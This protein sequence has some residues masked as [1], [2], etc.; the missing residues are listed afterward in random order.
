MTT[1]QELATA[2]TQLGR[3]IHALLG[4]LRAAAQH[5]QRALATGADTKKPH[6]LHRI[7]TR[8]HQRRR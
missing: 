4:P 8:Y 3:D 6:R 1:Q 5:M 2:L 7:K